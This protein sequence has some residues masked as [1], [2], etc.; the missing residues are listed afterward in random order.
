MRPTNLTATS[1][2]FAKKRARNVDSVH[3]ETGVY[4]K[5]AT[6]RFTAANDTFGRLA[7]QP[8]ER[9]I[10]AS[11]LD[12]IP[13]S[14]W[15]TLEQLERRALRLRLRRTEWLYCDVAWTDERNWRVARLDLVVATCGSIL[16]LSGS[17]RT[18][19]RA[20]DRTKIGSHLLPKRSRRE[21]APRLATNGRFEQKRAQ[22]DFALD[23]LLAG[24]STERAAAEAGFQHVATFCRTFKKAYGATTRELLKRLDNHAQR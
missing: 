4:S 23:Q 15:Q 11:A 6:L 14:F 20:G 12:L 5:D 1:M 2:H 16:G 18:L 24:V 21:D 8:A 17:L 19:P 22:L 9:L 3:C 13:Q 7:A 10:G